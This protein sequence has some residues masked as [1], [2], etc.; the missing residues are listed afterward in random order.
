MEGI[1]LW[2]ENDSTKWLRWWRSTPKDYFTNATHSPNPGELL[3]DVGAIFLAC[4]AAYRGE[5]YVSPNP[6]VGC[7]IRA[8][9][10]KFLSFGAHLQC[11]EAHAEINA[12]NAVSREN[13][14]GAKLTV[15]L[16]PCAHTGRTG[17]CAEYL[18]KLPLSSVNF[19]VVDP[20]PR[21]SGQ[22]MEILKSGGLDVKFEK[23]FEFLGREVA[24]IFLH[25]VIS[26][27]VFFGLKMA[28]SHDLVY[29]W[30]GEAKRWV[31]G[32]RAREYGHYLRQRYDAIF[33]GP[34]TLK[35]DLPLL[36]VRSA[37]FKARNPI[38][39]FFDSTGFF[40]SEMPEAYIQKFLSDGAI[41]IVS[42]SIDYSRYTKQGTKIIP[43]D[44][45]KNGH[46]NWAQVKS[47]LWK[48][49]IKS[50]LLEGGAG[51]WQ[52]AV[53][54]KQVQKM[55]WFMSPNKLHDSSGAMVLDR[56]MVEL[57]K[58]VQGEFSLEMDRYFEWT[59]DTFLLN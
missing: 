59:P 57:P 38:R 4:M 24:E 1:P 27:S 22:G 2:S 48:Q 37:K 53:K 19:L 5:G 14:V 41:A 52:S 12:I 20:D 56:K 13:L 43:L 30:K 17:S 49:G 3:S 51:I 46:F 44:L 10:N 54:E 47:A 21:V 29:G 28:T 42:K 35:A 33:V 18:A 6:L 39:V 34:G 15:T 50:M 31:T 58:G 26:N 7:V 23:E 36:T 9:D 11:G 8:R 16:E 55:H 25:N 32:E 40:N 45:E